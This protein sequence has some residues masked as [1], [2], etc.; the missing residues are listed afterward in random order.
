MTKFMI[1]MTSVFLIMPFLYFIPLK[2]SVRE[3]LLFTS[4]A[5]ALAFGGL[6][7]LNF[8]SYWTSAGF[9]VCLAFISAYI[10]EK[11]MPYVAADAKEMKSKEVYV[12]SEPIYKKSGRAEESASFEEAVIEPSM[13]LEIS[14]Q[15]LAKE[16]PQNETDAIREEDL[17]L[18]K[19][20]A[21]LEL[22]HP[23][24]EFAFLDEG[25]K[26]L[27]DYEIPVLEVVEPVVEEPIIDRSMLFDE[28]EEMKNQ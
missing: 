4:L 12:K 7:T 25:R 28:I 8:L 19:D 14:L 17:F 3:K 13:L 16:S 11:K 15:S 23:E 5:F 27:S 18:T 1:L 26:I 21:G 20:A 2:I 10:V 9:I 22:L 6:F 24:E